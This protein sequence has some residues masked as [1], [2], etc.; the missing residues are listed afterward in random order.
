KPAITTALSREEFANL[1]RNLETGSIPEKQAAF[2]V[3]RTMADD[4][5]AKLLSDWTDILA[6]GRV[7]KELQL[8]LLEALRANEARLTPGARAELAIFEKAKDSRDALAN[9]RECLLGGSAEEGRK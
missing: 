2:S 9:W 6:A 7:P 3:L 5:A 8:D 1:S 4:R